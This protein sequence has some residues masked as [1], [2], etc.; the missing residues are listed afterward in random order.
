MKTTT[1]LLERLDAIGYALENT[2][3]AI[4]LIGLGSVGLEIERLDQY[5][6]LDFFVIVAEGSR[7]LF[8]SSLDWLSAVRPLAYTFRNT[9][10]GFKALF[11]DGVFC[12]FA[13]FEPHDLARIPFAPGRVVWSRSDVDPEIAR[14]QVALAQP[15]QQSKAWCVGEALT[16]LYVGMCRFARGE[17]LSAF[18]FVQVYAVDRVVELV[19]ATGAESDSA[20]DPF[21]PDR[22]FEQ[23]FP[24]IAGVLSGFTQGYDRTPE[25]A[26]SILAF[27]ED[28]YDVNAS[29]ARRI[30]DLCDGCDE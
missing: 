16:N 7:Q 21:S 11:D 30:R 18:R 27:L 9:D 19:S 6:D 22:R 17:R 15:K 28:R 29:I 3:N 2:E 1:A 14:P 8:L 10:D 4:A 12:E 25:S 13:V 26:R 23:R 24:S 5:S 20:P